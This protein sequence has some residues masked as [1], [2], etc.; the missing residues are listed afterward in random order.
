MARLIQRYTDRERVN[1]WVTALLFLAAAFSGLALF[2]PSLWFLSAF[3]GGG[4][5]ARI[6]HPFLG[7]LMFLAFGFLALRLWRD[8]R[9]T[10]VDR[11]W[12]KNAGPM[13]RGDKHE[14]ARAGKYNAGQKAIFWLFAVCLLVLL[15]TGVLFWQPYFAPAVPVTLK[16]VAV[17][18]HAI[19]AFLL[20]LGV[21]VHVYAAIWVKGSVRAMTRGTVTEAWAREHHPLWAR[22][23]VA[24]PPRR[25]PPQ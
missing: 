20:V 9:W 2:H 25:V 3:V 16:R 18:L 24:E 14:L 1:H 17:L 19:A 22:D 7:V 23:A 5:W 21:I 8:N 12:M 13:L 10:A 4:N 15:V 6:L 11:E